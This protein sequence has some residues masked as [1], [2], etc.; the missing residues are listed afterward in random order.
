MMW[1][2]VPE[3]EHGMWWG[4]PIGADTEEEVR[5]AATEAW[6]GKLSADIDVVIYRCDHV[7]VLKL[8]KE[9]E[10]E[11][12]AAAAPAAAPAEAARCPHTADLFN[13]EKGAP[14]P[15]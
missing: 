6:S 14:S 11:E 7:D 5:K 13:D 15:V 3:D 2:A 8:P 9:G 1:I 10:T 12:D 4:D